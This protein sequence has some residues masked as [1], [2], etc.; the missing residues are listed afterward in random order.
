VISQTGLRALEPDLNLEAFTRHAHAFGGDK[1]IAYLSGG[2][3]SREQIR[4]HIRYDL[5]ELGYVVSFE[6]AKLMRITSFWRKPSHGSYD[7]VSR[8]YVRAIAADGSLWHGIGPYES[9]TYVTMHRNKK[10][11]R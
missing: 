4:P 3:Y 9:G 10:Q 8:I 5:G 1:L 6:G 11:P 2:R 7:P